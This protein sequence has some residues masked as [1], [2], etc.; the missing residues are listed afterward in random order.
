MKTCTVVMVAALLL[1][2]VHV[3]HAEVPID[4]SNTS[5]ATSGKTGVVLSG[6]TVEGVDGEF[7][8]H[9]EWNPVTIKFE[10][11]TAGV[12]R[13]ESSSDV[14]SSANWSE[15][16]TVTVEM[17]ELSSTHFVFEPNHLTF[18]AGRPYILRI[19]NANGNASKH[20]LTASEFYKSIAT[21]K[22]QTADAE[23]KAPF[24]KAFELKTGTDRQL[25]L[26]FVPMVPGEYGFLC[27][28]PGHAELGMTGTIT[29]VGEPQ[30][31]IDLQ[32]ASEWSRPLDTDPRASSSH[33]VWSSRE[34]VEVTLVEGP[35]AGSFSF[36]PSSVALAKDHAYV[37]KIH[38]PT[39]NVKHYFTTTDF[40]RTLVL[41]KAE[42]SHAEIKAP[43]FN[44]IELMVGGST[45]LFI[46]PTK[47]GIYPSLCTIPG[48]AAGGMV[49]SVTVQ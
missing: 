26:F 46:V 24:F 22:A 20:Y 41:R 4:L 34:T 35:E 27:T 5:S 10:L 21:R 39:G 37:L 42:D 12:G 1:V 11:G 13:V 7:W 45:E 29:V 14:V 47:S 33:E 8:A 15:V 2:S 48:H 28:I 18:T 6:I 9:M 43:Y 44:A 17:K 31:P 19:K 40:Y 32:V 3:A 23:Y 16:E 38:N 25:E 49:G 30:N 36:N